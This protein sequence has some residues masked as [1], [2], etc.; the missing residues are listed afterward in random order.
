MMYKDL[1]PFGSV[2]R[3]PKCG[4]DRDVFSVD[5]QTGELIDGK[6]MQP[7]FGRIDNLGEVRANSKA[8]SNFDFLSVTCHN[9]NYSWKELTADAPVLVTSREIA[10]AVIDDKMLRPR[11]V[12]I[13]DADGVD[14][15]QAKEAPTERTYTLTLTAD[16]ASTLRSIL[17]CVGGSH[18]RSRRR[19]SEEVL[20]KLHEVGTP[21]GG[22]GDIDSAFDKVMFLEKADDIR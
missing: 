5:Y 10:E 19:F 18:K 15:P 16:E 9:C 8:G 21:L 11:L 22:Y 13:D 6:V 1:L 20:R 17:G 12:V 2:E 7:V 14:K 3:C 4:S